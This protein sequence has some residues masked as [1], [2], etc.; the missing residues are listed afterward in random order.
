MYFLHYTGGAGVRRN[1]SLFTE[2]RS[3]NRVLDML[4][5]G[6]VKAENM[7]LVMNNVQEFERVPGLQLENWA[8]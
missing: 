7:V 6:H 2:Q 1:Q 4:I 3:S 8:E 5:A